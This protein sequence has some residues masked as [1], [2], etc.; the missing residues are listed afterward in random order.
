VIG[1]IG[2]SFTI[3]FNFDSSH[4]ELLLNELRLLS[5]ECCLESELCY[6]RRSVGQSILEYSTHLGLMT[7]FLLL[8]YSW[9][10]VCVERFL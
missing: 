3:T 5:N 9:G 2:T 4:I 8:L 10:V 1:F 7:R 6:D